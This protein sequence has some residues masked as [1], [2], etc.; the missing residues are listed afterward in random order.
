LRLALKP[1]K[2]QY[3]HIADGVDYLGFRLAGRDIR[4]QEEKLARGRKAIEALLAAVAAPQA[5]IPARGGALL[6]MNA[7]IRGFRNYFLIDDAPLI[8]EQLRSLDGYLDQVARESFPS[9]LA[10]ELAWASRDRFAPD[11]GGPVHGA[12]PNAAVAA[13]GSY[14]EVHCMSPR[15]DWITTGNAEDRITEPVPSPVPI[16]DRG[17]E[18]EGAG[19]DIFLADGRMHVMGHGCY[20][21]VSRDDLVVRRRRQEVFRTPT[22]A[23]TLLY[24]EGA[25]IALSADL[26]VRLSRESV[27]VVFA[28]TVGSPA[29]M[30]QPV[31]GERSRARQQQVLRRDDP[32]ILRAG[33]AML[34][35]KVGNQASV[36]KYFARYR[37]QRRDPVYE[38][39]TESARRIRDV[40]DILGR[41]DPTAAGI[42]AS[43]MGHEG[44]A[45]ALYWSALAALLPAELAFPGRHTRHATDAV[46]SAI[47]YAYGMLYA[48]VWRVLMRAGLD[49]YFG[50]LHGA[51]QDQGSLVFDLIEEYRAPFGDRLILGMVGRGFMPLLDQESRLRISSRRKLADAFH[52]LWRRKI[53]WRGGMRA[54]ADIL[55]RQAIALRNTYIGEDRYEPFKFRW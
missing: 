18:G 7:F 17:D 31:Q 37:K 29:A 33:L 24:L 52:K 36:L 15:A 22:S 11:G 39:L 49:P 38:T 50:I 54:P 23:L 51:E 20:V 26:T 12:D 44:R 34:A 21:T 25:G 4:I 41:L 43:A 55:E 19:G 9:R 28:P 16:A 47:N 45:A 48:E 13:T 35:A 6:R 14:P 46:N 53:R 42:R 30:T 1:A 8:V 5:T 32:E 40:A 2:T 3:C 10:E 27:P